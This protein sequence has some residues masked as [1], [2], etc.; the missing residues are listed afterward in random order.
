[1]PSPK[2]LLNCFCQTLF[3]FIVLLFSSLLAHAQQPVK[4][5]LRSPNGEPLVGAT[6]TVKGTNKSVTTNEKGEFTIDAP[7]GSTLVFSYIGF[8]DKEAKAKSTPINEILSPNDGTLND[9]VVI[10]YQTVRKKDLTGAVSIVDINASKKLTATTV[11]ESLQGL[12]A[13]VTV[14]NT[15]QPGGEAAVEIRGIGSL[16]S[17]N[18]FYVIDGL[19]ATNANRDFNANDIESVQILKDASAAAIYGARAANGVIIITTK[20][21]KDGPLKVGFSA[22]YGIQQVPK[23]WN[24]MDATQFAATNKLAYQNGGVT[25]MASVSTAFNPAINTDWQDAITRTGA[26]QDYDL[27]FSGGSKTSSY[28]ISG[29]YFKSLGTVINNDY[30]RVSLRVNSE[31]RKGIFKIGENL[32]IY[33]SHEDP[34]EGTPFIDMVR[35]LPVIPIKDPANPGGYGYGSDKAVTFGT[36]PV[37]INNLRQTDYSNVRLRGNTYAEI[38]PFKWIKYR[39]NLGLET[40]F[41]HSKVFRKDGNWTYNQ[42]TEQPFLNESRAQSLHLLTE[43]TLN[44]NYAVKKHRIDGVAG[45]SYEKDRYEQMGATKTGYT[46]QAD[47]SYFQVLDQGANNSFIGGYTNKWSAYSAFGR[48]NYNYD[49]RYLLSGTFRRDADSRFGPNNKVAYFPSYS[50]AWRISNESFFHLGWVNDLKIR[51]SYGTLG[52]ITIGP[53]QYLGI[54]NPNPRYVFG[55]NN[56]VQGSTQTNLSNPDLKWESKKVTNIGIDF[57]LLDNRISGNIDYYKSKSKDV[58]TYDV[59]FPWYLGGSGNPPVNAASLQNTGVELSIN[60]KN[61]Q[62]KFKYDIGLNVT[63]IKNKIL[64]LGNLGVGR[65]YVQTGLTRTEVGRSLG[66]FYGYKTA[67]IFQSASE[68]ASSDQPYAQP[69]DIRFV[70]NKKDGDLTADDRQ[71]LGSPWPKLETGL[72]FNASYKGFDASIQLY[73]LFGRK[74]YNT[75][76]SI[77]DRVVDNS[78][79][80][81]NINPWTPSNTNTNFPRLVYGSARSV[82]ENSR[83]DDDRWLENG[84]FVKVRNV[85]VAYNVPAG[86]LKR[87]GFANARIYISGQNLLTFTGSNVIDPD[88]VGNNFFERGVVGGGYPSSRIFTAGIQCG[89]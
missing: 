69:G 85:Q 83:G 88:I 23:K 26:I 3:L 27:S 32:G 21:G 55:D 82:S 44:L 81:T 40:S 80:R 52:N 8:L 30:D 29:N 5:T 76:Y 62:H 54:I 13:G 67:G 4:G 9:A 75:I 50:A 59:P 1:M 64:A 14:R 34:V 63:T 37:A 48:V 45:F 47:G 10:G 2:R 35:M 87:I 56:P 25:P 16:L 18:P 72:N 66:E 6:V 57:T 60:Y 84:S 89:F 53:W 7:E 22:K 31:G 46:L 41:D 38:E 11:G 15:G 12:A 61:N 78:N 39:F 58:L 71:Y 33:S 17:N 79:Y 19:P 65:T 43:H 49:D 24:L 68:V 42:A 77:I 73:G 86:M 28:F 36:N 20:R 70:S 51:G 74:I